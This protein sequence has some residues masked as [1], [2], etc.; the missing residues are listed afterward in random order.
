VFDVIVQGTPQTRR[1]VS[2]VRDL[3]I[4]KPDGGHVRLGS[5]ADVRVART[6]AVINRDAVSRYLDIEADVSGRGLGDVAS[7][8]ENRLE[9][10]SLP[11]EYHAEVLQRATS[12]E[13]NVGKVVA[14][15]LGC[16]IAAFLLLQAAFWSWRLA[17]LAFV[18]LPV[19]LTGG[20][21]GA[22]IDGAELKLGALIGL[23][24]LF[25]IAAR[26]A[27]V[28]IRHYQDL[29]RSEGETFGAGLV[30]RGAQERLVP[31]LASTIATALVMLPLIVMGSTAGLEVLNP[32]AIVVLF[33]LVTSAALG[34]F[35]LPALYLRFG[36]RQAEI[37]P[38]EDLLHRWAA[39]EPA[40]APAGTGVAT[41]S[42]SEKDRA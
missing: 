31:I 18:T 10:V 21:V 37:S 38:E 34:L 12:K 24:A 15:A 41:R 29:Q 36:S 1:S 6:P 4:D 40:D 3:V 33:G 39:A 5:V 9:K 20:A 26:N 7:D 32:M 11:L 2:A 19:A 16:L 28:L 30:V 27:T 23:L 35:V 14:F 13:I 25:A 17:A 8:I 42:S 22:L